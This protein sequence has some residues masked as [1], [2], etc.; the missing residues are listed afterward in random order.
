LALGL[1]GQ[2]VAFVVVSMG[3]IPS[4]K[5]ILE[6]DGLVPPMNEKGSKFKKSK[7]RGPPSPVPD[8]E[9]PPWVNREHQKIRVHRDSVWGTTVDV[10]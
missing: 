3:C 6:E 8:D 7:S 5:R 9:P 4:K 1:Q 10:R 2:L